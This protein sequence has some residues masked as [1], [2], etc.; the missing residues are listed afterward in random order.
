MKKFL[1]KR[2]LWLIGGKQKG[3]V[4]EENWISI[5]IRWDDGIFS[6]YNKEE[7]KDKIEI[8]EEEKW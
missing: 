4:V 7:I 3:T 5:K 6:L 1:D 2:V 8:I